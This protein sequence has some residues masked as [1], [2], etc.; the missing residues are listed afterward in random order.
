[1]PS[2]AR[3]LRWVVDMLQRHDVVFQ[4][5]GGL[6]ARAYGATRPLIDLDFYLP[7]R[8]VWPFLLPEVAGY[9]TWGPERH[10]GAHWDITFVKLTY[11][12]Q[13]I[14]FGD[15]SDAFYF[16]PEAR[17]WLRQRVNYGASEW[18]EVLGVRIPVM[19][20]SELVAY[21]RCLDR[22]VDQQDLLEIANGGPLA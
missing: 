2:P 4:A 21:K 16:D 10:S 14:E 11:A 12:G 8:D 1:M 20:L 7:L 22:P 9:V 19:P 13:P 17:K 15:S 5:A 6:A 18:H 3:A